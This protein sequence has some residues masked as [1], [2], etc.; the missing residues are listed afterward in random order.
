MGNKPA[1][2]CWHARH[3]PSVVDMQW[4][5]TVYWLAE[6][7]VRVDQHPDMTHAHDVAQVVVN[8]T[9][10]PVGCWWFWHS[11]FACDVHMTAAKPVMM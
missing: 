11:L 2:T 4:Q 3:N 10:Q 1:E 7:H 9:S 8:E 5:L 6:L